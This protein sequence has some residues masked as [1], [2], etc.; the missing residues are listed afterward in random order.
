MAS[1]SE[2]L[3]NKQ[4][5]NA[6]HVATLTPLVRAAESRQT[7]GD[8]NYT[9]TRVLT[10]D[11]SLLRENRVVSAMAR[12]PVVDAYKILCIQVLQRLRERKGNALAVVSPGEDEGKTL[13]AINLAISLAQE[14]DQTVL[15][16]DANLR[17]PA[18]HKYFGFTPEAGFS[19]YLIHGVS[20]DRLLVNPGI[21]RLVILPGGRPL[22]NSAEMLGSMKMEALVL[23]LKSRYPSRIVLF[24][25]P[26]VLSVADAMAFA[27]YVDAALMVVQENKTS[28]AEV[29]RSAEM[30]KSVDLLGTVLNM[31]AEAAVPEEDV[32]ANWW[33]RL[34]GRGQ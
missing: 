18:V 8:I 30:L 21:D 15:L 20:L 9:K 10:S 12:G 11:E 33:Q 3:A 1:L 32:H 2:A 6:D 4:A 34:L 19:D 23:E 25:L 31:A 7:V 29:Q 27:P 26:P 13:T 5:S 24:D 17:E 16:V 28:R 22:H 14:V